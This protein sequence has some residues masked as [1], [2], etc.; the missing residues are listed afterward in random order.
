MLNHAGRVRDKRRMQMNSDECN[1]T[2]KPRGEK[3]EGKASGDEN[4]FPRLRE[5]EPSQQ[6]PTEKKECT[7]SYEDSA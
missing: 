7:S 2:G 3:E 5:K 1:P 6:N 4:L